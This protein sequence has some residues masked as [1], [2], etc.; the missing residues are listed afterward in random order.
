MS[1][2]GKNPIEIPSGTTV[3]VDGQTV[4]AKGKLGE[5]QLE[6][7]AT[8]GAEIEDGKLVIKPKENPDRHRMMWGTMRSL[9][10][11][12]VTGVTEGFVRNLEINGV[13]Y[14]AQV[15]GKAL[16]LQ[17]GFSHDVVFPIPDG[18]EIRCERPTLVEIKGADKQRVGQIAS[19]I[20]AFR[21]PEPY[22]GKGVKYVEEQIF[23]KE[24]K[25]K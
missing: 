15:D 13:G 16:K 25:K 1:R 20:R 10:Q 22:K 24:G 11:S 3:T 9:A 6:L 19:E 8:I 17:L 21:P 12:L 14:R 23:R 5:R 18:I 7:A 2:V 4:K